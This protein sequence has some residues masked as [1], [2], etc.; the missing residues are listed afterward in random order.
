MAN[1]VNEAT[2][3]T[4]RE[5][6]M[7]QYERIVKIAWRLVIF[8]ILAAILIFIGLS[9]SGL[10]S[11]EE[12]ENPKSRDA[13]Q[14]YSSDGRVLG[15]YYIENR[16]R[17]KYED[18]SPHVVNALISTEDE[19]FYKHSGVDAKALGRAI[20]NTG[21]LQRKNSG[22]GSTIT[23]QLAKLLFTGVASRNIFQR[24]V[25]KTKEWIVAVKLERSYTKE[26]IMTMYLN[27]F[28]FING[29]N[30][31]KSAS[32]T[33][34]GTTPSE[35]KLE[36]AAVLVGMLKNPAI[37]NPKQ[38]P[39]DSKK[40]REVVLYQMKKN[41]FINQTEYDSLRTLPVDMGKF[42]R[43][44]HNEGLAPY[45]R[46][47]LRSR[48]KGILRDLKKTD[49]TTYDL[50]RDGLR[51][52]TTID[53]RMQTHAENAVSEHMKG[54]QEK[55]FK[56]WS[57]LDP[58]T[59]KTTENSR[60][61]KIRQKGFNRLVKS[62]DRY[63]VWRN[64]VLLKAIELEL[65][66]VDIERMK[67]IE[68]EGWDLMYKWLDT[69]FINKKLAAK[70]KKVLGENFKNDDWKIVMV[71]WTKL[72]RLV[73][74]DFSKPVKMTVFAYNAPR[75]ETD[76][77]MSPYD[78]IRYNR[79]ILQAG[80]LAVDPV[81]GY[82]KAWVG[83]VNHKYFQLDHVTTNRQVGSTFKPLI[84][85][86]AMMREFTPCDRVMDQ[87]TTLE[88]GTF[89]LL[90]DW[91][92]KNANFKYSG[93]NMTLTEAL[94]KS[95][96]SISASLMKDL[97]TV[98]PVRDLAGRMGID[99][100]KIPS[101]PSI[102]LGTPDLSVFEMTGAYTAFANEGI[103]TKPTYIE[104][105]EDKFGNVIY[106]AMPEQRQVL[107]ANTYYSMVHLLRGVVGGVSA[108]RGIKSDVGGKTGTTSNFTDG[109]FMGVTP[110]LVAG[111][112]VGGEDQWIRF[113]TLTYGQGGRM[114][115][116][117]FASFLKKVEKDETLNFDKEKRFKR[118]NSYS[119]ELNCELYQDVPDGIY[120]EEYDINV[121]S[122]SVSRS[123]ADEHY[124]E[125]N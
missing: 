63:A 112:W 29:G 41:G 66:D 51:V 100:S 84:Y 88:A 71:E 31:I 85:S 124:D 23:Q 73:K 56:R 22:G 95:V 67:R 28:D 111:T 55:F 120:D 125:F 118:P 69:D 20:V 121:G 27:E 70:Y 1:P 72:Q 17:I 36:E 43:L 7:P 65:R 122:D 117:I 102:C 68:E 3:Q 4:Y 45:F 78:S 18:L 90:K 99:K 32:E 50:Y 104:R 5:E 2:G 48:V 62:S 40:R 64:A 14:V 81:T 19:R 60:G 13:S 24:L 79:M 8:G 26:E 10:P 76:T 21:I 96:N 54:L 123:Q 42:R 11:F 97:G 16:V 77:I 83:G 52:Y 86:Q 110:N 61:R 75:Y 113:R 91:T 108:F 9:F 98:E 115:R 37:Y 114:A 106:E 87:A 53:A 58:W 119:V 107:D 34:F 82:V 57:K 89:G 59:Y 46:E 44:D 93:K 25:Q 33:Y 103:Y 35:L 109:W 12:L 80:M 74:K 101:A 30:G 38:N 105:I 94:K 92:P 39:K 47:V 15:R 49:G 6:R 116:P